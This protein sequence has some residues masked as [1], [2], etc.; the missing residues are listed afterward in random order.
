[1]IGRC[2]RPSNSDYCRYGAKGIKVSVRWRKS[3]ATFLADVGRKPS[4]EHTLDRY[5]NKYG[6]YAPGNVRWATPKE[7]A[8]NKKNN[9]VIRIGGRTQVAAQWADEYKINRNVF[10]GRLKRGMRPLVALTAPL[11]GRA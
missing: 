4:R 5:P 7:Q 11:R 3:F 2:H 1:M 9:I 6:D 8:C 10:Y